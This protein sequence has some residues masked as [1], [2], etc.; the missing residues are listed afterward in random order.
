VDKTGSNTNQK[1]DPLQGN[2]KRIVG[3]NGDSFG[4][5]GS[6]SN[7]HF[8]VMCFQSGTGEPV[9]L[10]IIFKSDNKMRDIPLHW[11]TG[12]DI[13]KLPHVVALPGQ[14]ANIGQLYNN[15]EIDKF[16]A[17]GGGACYYFRGNK[18]KT[19][20]CCSPSA[21]I[22]SD[23]LTNMLQ[24][25]DVDKVYNWP[26]GETPILILDGH[27]SC[28]DIKFLEYI[29]QPEHKWFV[30]L[31]VPYGTHKWQV[32]DSLQVNRQFKIELGK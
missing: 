16:V 24:C 5:W 13:C 25:M 1:S 10:A 32:A 21:S 17:L 14:E 15:F 30:C 9:K 8:T 7:N 4:L 2:K 29:S 3:T 22:T 19:Y 6:I 27:H 20:C 31:G 26:N 28:M 12:I 18:I 23:I 11:V